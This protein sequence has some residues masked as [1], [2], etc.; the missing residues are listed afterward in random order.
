MRFPDPEEAPPPYEAT[1]THAIESVELGPGEERLACASW[2]VENDFP[3]YVTGTRFANLGSFHHSNWFVVPDTVY[4]GPDG[5]WDCDERGFDAIAAV[6]TGTVLFAQS[7]QAWTERQ[8][9]R[10]GATIRIPERSRIVAEVHL[11]NLTPASRS[12]GAWISLD[13]VHPR[14]HIRNLEPLQ[15]LYYDLAIPAR[16]EVRF[17][18][19]CKFPGGMLLDYVL[20]HYHASG[21]F[22]ELEVEHTDGTSTSLYRREDFDAS[23]LGRA[24]G[25]PV[26]IEEEERLRFTCGYDNWYSR[27]L[28]WGIGIDEMCVVFGLGS[29]GGLSTGTVTSG[30]DL[31]G[32]MDGVPT[33]SGPCDVVQLQG[34]RAF[35]RPLP[36]EVSAPLY[37]P[38]NIEDVDV[39]PVPACV[40]AHLDGVSPSVAPTFDNVVDHVF[41]PWCAFSGCHGDGRAAGLDLR[42]RP[43]LRDELL[44]HELLPG[45]SR[46]LI[47]PGEPDESWIYQLLS[48]CEPVDD[49]GRARPH[50]PYNAPV[51]LD[52]QILA[53]VRDWLVAGAP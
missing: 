38:R 28:E 17:S 33:Y 53:L 16:S 47:S 18:G 40:D 34:G 21:N 5:I 48:R 3:L 8:A 49:E 10:E 22:F 4:E 41:E 36:S 23:A 26:E 44:S 7:T 24:F 31:V 43:S 52:P 19:S 30:T 12:T 1:V 14:Y 39:P 9:F 6:Q 51:L 42:T 35:D 20:P 15:L 25:K 32:L 50:M 27:D 29:F 2:T 46:P 13:L 45:T 37:L 11:L